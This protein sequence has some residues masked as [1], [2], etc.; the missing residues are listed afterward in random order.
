MPFSFVHSAQREAAIVAATPGTTRDIVELSLNLHGFPVVLADTAGLRSTKDEV[1]SI[2]IER[3]FQRYYLRPYLL[4][5]GQRNPDPS[6]TPT[7]EQS[8]QI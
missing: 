6:S 3:A 8:L 5:T 7:P 2:G 1:E 4:A